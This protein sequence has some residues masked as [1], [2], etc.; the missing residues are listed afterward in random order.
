MKSITSKELQEWQDRAFRFIL[1]DVREK[2]EHEAFNIGGTL[3][4]LSEL[5]QHLATFSGQT[6]I[7]FYC[8]RGIRS[9]IAIQKLSRWGIQGDFY[10]L[11]D[12]IAAW[13]KADG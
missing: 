6:P 2:D 5:Q 13:Q 9:Q 8:K 3:V 12:G 11:T 10:N 1:I 4:P 7:V